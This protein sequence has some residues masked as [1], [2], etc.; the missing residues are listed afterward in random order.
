MLPIALDV[1]AVELAA[2]LGV[3]VAPYGPC[4][5][6]PGTQDITYRLNTKSGSRALAADLDIRVP[7]GLCCEGG[8]LGTMV[9][10]MLV[11]HERLVVKA[12]R[13]AGGYR[14]CR[15]TRADPG[16][17]PQSGQW[18]VEQYLGVVRSVSVQGEV[19]ESGP[20]LAFSGGM[21]TADAACTGYD[22]PLTAC[23][24]GVG[25]DLDRWASVLGRHLAAHGY[26][27]TFGIDAVMDS[28]CRLLATE[29]NV[30][31]TATTTPHA[32]VDRLR[33]T[34]GLVLYRE[35]AHDERSIPY[36]V[37]APDPRRAAELE[38]RLRD[39]MQSDARP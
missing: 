22:S 12:N 33:R 4:G 6:A 37:L 28:Q 38:A 32:M 11:G 23:P 1:P 18:V 36:A 3:P 13:A 5:V 25:K 26:R 14:L 16:P 20:R 30:R 10:A 35:P 17:H 7:L 15:V 8:E 39:V 19:L 2:R 24:D 31:R 34:A 9:A 29:S 21:R 27:G